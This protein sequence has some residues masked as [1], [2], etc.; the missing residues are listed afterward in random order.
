MIKKH[1]ILVVDNEELFIAYIQ[2][3]SSDENYDVI[4]ACSGQ[5]GLEILEKQQVS[6]VISEYKI[7]LMNGL[8]FLEKVRIIY[9]DILTIMVTDHVDIKLAIKAVNEAGVYKFLLKPWDDIEFKNTI[10]KTLESLQVIK[11]RDVLIRKVKTHEVTLKDL[12]KR[13]PGIT[14]VE[15]DEDGYI[16]P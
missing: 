14:K 16:L 3:V 4:T 8:E 10:K 5:E 15:R 6:M 7:P 1:T 2:R 13:Y 9:P 12:E 11:E